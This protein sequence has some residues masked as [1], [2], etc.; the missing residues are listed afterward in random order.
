ME[1]EQRR[2]RRWRPAKIVSI[3]ILTEALSQ[4]YICAVRNE[5]E[6]HLSSPLISSSTDHRQNQK[7]Q[8][9]T[10]ERGSRERKELLARTS[11]ICCQAEIAEHGCPEG[12][13]D[14][15]RNQYVT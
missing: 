4:T 9:M 2:R 14:T 13:A 10:V 3:R 8:Q 1:T 7:T 12:E 15:V 5:I 11:I 6:S